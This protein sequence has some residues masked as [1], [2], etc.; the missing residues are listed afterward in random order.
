MSTKKPPLKFNW[1]KNTD[2]AIFNCLF[3]QF[4]KMKEK[5]QDYTE[6]AIL[7]FDHTETNTKGIVG[8]KITLQK[9]PYKD[10]LIFDHK[11]IIWDTAEQFINQCGIIP[12]KYN[13]SDYDMI[14][15]AMG[16]F[17]LVTIDRNPKTPT[18]WFNQVRSTERFGRV[19]YRKND[20]KRLGQFLR[21]HVIYKCPVNPG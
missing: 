14:K 1:V 20:V 9:A 19:I 12:K 15:E 16:Y 17:F 7:Q 21:T 4:P 10:L 8:L 2:T 18:I 11:L 5:Y 13:V 6:G 3:R